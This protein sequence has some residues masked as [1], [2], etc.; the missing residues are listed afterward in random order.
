M[1][2]IR[3]F[4]YNN[5]FNII[6]LIVWLFITVVSL[7]NHEIWRD[8]AQAWC[9]VRDLDLI[10]IFK[11]IRIEGHPF[12]W[13]LILFPFAKLGFP[14]ISMQI[15][16]LLFVFTSVI[17]L[18]FK[19]PFNKFEK[20]IICFSAGLLY[21]LPIISRN[22][23]LIPIFLFAIA[24]LYPR[25]KETPYL[26]TLFL[27][28]L[29]NTHLYL[30]GFCL[31]TGTLF[32]IEKIKES[33]EVKSIKPLFPLII[34]GLNFLILLFTFLN[35]T[36]ENYALDSDIRMALSFTGV[37]ILI[38][39]TFLYNIALHINFLQKHFNIISFISFYPFLIAIFLGFVRV[40][41]KIGTICLLS[42]SYMFFV[43]TKVYFNGIL[44][45][46]AYLILLVLIAC[47]WM[48]KHNSKVCIYTIIAI[49]TLFTL[50]TIISPFVIFEDIKY[51][52]SGGK[53]IAKY[54]D[55]NLNEETIFIALGNPFLYSSVSAY[56]PN[57]KI[58]NVISESYISYYS[59][60][61]E[62]NK[63]TTEFPQNVRYSIVQENI[64]VSNNSYLNFVFKT[65]KEN[66][67]SKSEREIFSIY[68][69]K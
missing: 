12:L 26:Y 49:Y 56:L 64:D 55:E 67:S 50:S 30:L 54:I 14:V 53:Q 59:F 5:K 10:N 15:I 63:T 37:L 33:Y 13:Y 41:K 29:S 7:F 38:S 42:I 24:H 11:L 4:I 58:Y 20:I 19:S 18:L 60:F 8:E 43:Y 52:F 51:N 47:F 2:N 65:N 57:K 44:Y 27:I 9:M 46:K 23:A 40:D 32:L 3:T 68:E 25:R 28:L 39:K 36:N 45:Q 34:L 21:F 22:Y 62:K 31:V 61:N 16:S 6:L 48:V 35:T 66:I 69:Q 1:Q 17:L